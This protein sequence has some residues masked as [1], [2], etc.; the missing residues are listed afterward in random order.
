VKKILFFIMAVFLLMSMAVYS[1]P[2]S[3]DSSEATEV[4]VNLKDLDNE[5]ASRILNKM[6]EKEKDKTV[7]LSPSK[8]DQWREIAQSLGL[9]VK[10]LC[11]ALNVEINAFIKTD[12][13]K[14]LTFMLIWKVFG[15]QLVAALIR[16]VIWGTI[17]GVTF[18]SF[19][20]FHM[21]RK[22]IGKDNKIEYVPRY[23]WGSN[24]AKTFSVAAH[25][26]VAIVSALIM[27]F[28]IL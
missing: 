2:S 6:R 28:A 1:A 16:F 22:E 23:N 20:Y 8:V 13:G 4:T 25:V 7:E 11:Q 12:A 10:E 24:E 21:S 17:L 5:T 9:A 19:R 27:S 14:L 15:A 18:W 26:I 3:G